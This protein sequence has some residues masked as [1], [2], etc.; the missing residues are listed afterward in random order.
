[1]SNKNFVSTTAAALVVVVALVALFVWGGR[2]NPPVE[3]EPLVTPGVADT[4]TLA[5]CLKNKGVVMYG[6]EW[7]PHCQNQK[8]LFGAAVGLISYVECPQEPEKCLAAGIQGY[9]TWIFPDG[10]QLPGEQTLEKLAEVS[11]CAL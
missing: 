2:S 9:P 5:Q 1:M 3:Q 11:G 4:A 8:K 6:A 7:C 10:K